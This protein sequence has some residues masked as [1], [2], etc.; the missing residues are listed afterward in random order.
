MSKYEIRDVVSDYGI[1]EDGELKLILESRTNAEYIKSILEHEERH[2]DAAVPYS[3]EVAGIS[4]EE[5]LAVF[6]VCA[7]DANTC[8]KCP[9][10][11][12]EDCFI[13][14]DRRVLAIAER[15]VSAAEVAPKS[16][17]DW[18]REAELSK[19]ETEVAREI[20]EAIDAALENA[21]ALTN[22]DIAEAITKEDSIAVASKN[23]ALL[24][25]HT[26]RTC[27]KT[28]GR[29]YAGGE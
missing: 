12:L 2:S 24:M 26:I 11:N 3:P 23:G 27:L 6:R 18:H 20:F 1:Y 10:R 28:M 19:A 22:E 29:E 9:L 5:C 14:I 21:I 17:V 4:D 25:I 7:S 15:A 8:E 13:Q 16:E